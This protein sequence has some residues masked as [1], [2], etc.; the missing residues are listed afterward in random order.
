MVEEPLLLLTGPKLSIG[1]L[2]GSVSNNVTIN[3]ILNIAPKK[4]ISSMNN[5]D[6][7]HF[8]TIIYEI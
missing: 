6:T 8:K 7:N 1:K 3:N 5:C 4:K 2:S